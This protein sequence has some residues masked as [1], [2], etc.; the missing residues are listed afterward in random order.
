MDITGISHASLSVTDLDRSMQWYTDVLGWAKL[1]DGEAEGD[2]FAF[3]FI[4]SSVGLALRQP[5]GGSGD[6]FTADRTGL[7]HLA[8]AVGS[9]ADLEAWEKKFDENGVV[10][11]P[12]MDEAYGHVL[13]FKDPDN[14]ALEVFAPQA[15]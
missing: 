6:T 12:T 13:N 5:A 4:G 14:I 3:G 7:D 8:L 1:Y 2:R 9:R 15:G 10:Y 11:T